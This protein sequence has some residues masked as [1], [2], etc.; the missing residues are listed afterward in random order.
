VSARL[1]AGA[2]GTDG[3]GS[4]RFPAAYCGLTG[5]KFTWGTLPTDGFTLAG[6]SV[7]E[8]GPICRD[9]AD[10]RLLGE[11][12]CMTPL[13][14]RSVNGL[15]IGVPRAQLW[16]DLDPEVERACTMAL[17]V[18]R[19][20]GADVIELSLD[21]VEHAV[22]AAVLPLSLEMLPATKPQ[23]AAEIAP[24][25]ST[26]IRALTK[27]QL[28]M[29]AVASVKAERVRA[30][31]RR[32]VAREFENAD[33]LAWPSIPAP[34]PPIEDPTVTLPS[35]SHPADY[36]N[37]RLGGIANLTGLPAISVPCGFSGQGLPLGLQLLAPWGEDAR[38][39]D[40]AER[41]EEAT[42]R[43]FVEAAPQLAQEAPA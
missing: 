21:G 33:V 10:A 7:T 15:R 13:D 37:V 41:F 25:L 3:G 31:I 11:A 12:L 32:S 20:A 17:D 4:I 8:P 2:V 27:A 22:I 29:P 26:L 23:A 18:L 42:D 5:I 38:L 39:L 6:H 43:R 30:Q 1:V 40:F 28:L 19:D 34:A 24:H 36:A 35:G 16:N 14:S 9:A